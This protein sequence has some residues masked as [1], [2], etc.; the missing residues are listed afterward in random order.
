MVETQNLDFDK[1]ARQVVS[2]SSIGS[3]KKE[4]KHRTNDK[5][6]SFSQRSD[7]TYIQRDGDA[8]DSV[9]N[10]FEGLNGATMISQDDSVD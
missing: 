4:P 9:A 2:R 10:I 6:T 5:N 7:S 1:M 8:D 3:G